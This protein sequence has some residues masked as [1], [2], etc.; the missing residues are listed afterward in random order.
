MNHTVAGKSCHSIFRKQKNSGIPTNLPLT[1]TAAT[2]FH[3]L[4]FVFLALAPSSFLYAGTVAQ[5]DTMPDHTVQQ[6]SGGAG[7]K[8]D[9]AA[10]AQ[11][12]NLDRLIHETVSGNPQVLSKRFAYQ[13]ARDGVEAARWKFF[14]A[15]YVQLQQQGGEQLSSSYRRLEVYGV[16]Q[17]L[18]TGGQ[19]TTNLK[20]A[21]STALSSRWSVQE[22]RFALAQSVVSLYQ[23]LLAY[24]YRIHAQEIG[25]K[26]LEGYA[27]MMERRVRAGVSAQIDQAQVNARLYQAR[28]DLASSTSAHRV[29]MEQ[30]TQLVGKP[31]K[32]EQ[33]GFFTNAGMEMPSEPDSLLARAEGVNP[34]LARMDA[35]IETARYQRK[36][37]KAALFPNL[38]LK[39][40]HRNY[41]YANDLR[42]HENIVYASLEYSFGSGLSSMANIRSATARVGSYV[43][44]KEAMLLDLRAKIFADSEE[45]RR[46]LMLYRQASLTSKASA[47]V[48]ASYTRMFVAG[49]RSWLD[50]L[51]AA[52]ELTQSEVA[53]GDLLAAY[54]GSRYRLR[55]HAMD[56][57]LIPAN[58]PDQ[59]PEVSFRAV[60]SL[61]IPGQG[62]DTAGAVGTLPLGADLPGSP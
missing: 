44:A 59:P 62:T 48:L 21:N 30:M 22:T 16:Q 46:S 52:R 29:A 39:A 3:I 1:F 41:L 37:Q 19:L 38:S 40:E 25:V 42:L 53:E 31:L 24:H 17:P 45:C 43:Q 10:A 50:V 34:S 51:N 60:D 4:V 6:M 61:T 58:V 23:S 14:P 27:T 15:P 12:W 13:S 36:L 35:D 54:W 2:P 56:E 11:V 5:P 57:T 55:L 7:A 28:N 8:P 47:E 9:K 20:V 26:R 18:W 32:A 33:I 49:K